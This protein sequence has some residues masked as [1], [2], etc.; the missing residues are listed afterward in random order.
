MHA[1]ASMAR[2]AM[3]RMLLTLIGLAAIGGCVVDNTPPQGSITFAWTFAGEDCGPAGV[4]SVGVQ[5]FDVNGAVITN[6]SVACS[7]ESVTYTDFTT[8]DYSFSLAGLSSGGTT[9]YQAA[10]PIT[11]NHGSNQFDVNL[12]L[13]Q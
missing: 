2:L 8:G 6:D 13:A 5:I 1:E 7:A 10:G 4:A 11:V 9:L 12:S 3:V